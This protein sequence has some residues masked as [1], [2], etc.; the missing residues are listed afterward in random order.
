MKIVNYLFGERP[1]TR[2]AKAIF[3]IAWLSMLPGFFNADRHGFAWLN[4]SMPLLLLAFF[5]T[6]VFMTFA[7]K[8]SLID[9]W[10]PKL[11][12][13]RTLSDPQQGTMT[14]RSM[15]ATGICFMILIP[16]VVFSMFYLSR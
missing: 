11:R 4:Y 6:G 3:Y 14:V 5:A 12:L 10:R 1:A 15:R 16:C 7:S 9:Y 2:A 13:G 8:D